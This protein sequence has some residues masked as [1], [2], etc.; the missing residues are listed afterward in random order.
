MIKLETCCNK[1]SENNR[2]Y[3]LNKEKRHCIQNTVF[4]PKK[5]NNDDNAKE[6]TSHREILLNAR[7]STRNVLPQKIRVHN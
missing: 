6:L 7:T 3:C 5:N 2:N 4:L 1:H